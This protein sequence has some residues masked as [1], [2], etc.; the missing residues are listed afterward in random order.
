MAFQLD[1]DWYLEP[2]KGATGQTYMGTRA[3]ER[4]FIK[5]NTSPLLAAL[6]KEGIAPKLVWTKRTANGDILTAQQWLD[7]RVLSSSEIGQ[8][9]D[10]I[11]VLYQLHHSYM[12]K[13]MLQKIGGQIQTPETLLGN[14]EEKLPVEL[15]QNQYLSRVYQSLSERIPDYSPHNYT[16]VHGDVNHRNWLVS[17]NYLYLVDWDSVMLADPALDIGMILGHYVPKE[18]WNKWLLSYGVQADESVL[19]RIEWYV[20]INFLQEILRHQ[21]GNE[22]RAMNVEILKLKQLFEY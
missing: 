3:T 1:K 14:Y 9:N 20:I 8:R 4:V 21:Q 15:K 7:G 16:V 22:M 6:S 17:N 18:E 11:D 12:L 2:I 10:V 13:N 19:Q 5:R